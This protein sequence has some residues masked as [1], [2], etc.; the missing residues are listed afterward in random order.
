MQN[1]HG[2]PNSLTEAAI[3]GAEIQGVHHPD[4]SE[5]PELEIEGHCVWC[6]RSFRPRATGGSAQKFCAAGHR[7][8]FWNA[9]RLWTMRAVETGLLSVECLKANQTSVYAARGAFPV[10][11]S[12]T[13]P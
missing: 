3:R 4:R 2:L 7:K 8:A 6:G 1:I 5:N 11:G 13:C 10:A 12:R 9:A